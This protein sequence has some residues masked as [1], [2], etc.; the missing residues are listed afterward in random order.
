MKILFQGDS[1][2]DC[3]RRTCGGAGYEQD[4]VGPGYPGLIKS[5]LSC[6]RPGAGFEFV[7]LG[8]SGN[9]VVDLYA[10]WRA[11]CINLAPDV[12]SILI[13]VNDSW[14]EYHANG[15]EVPRYARIYGELLDWT[16][17][18]LPGVRFVLLEPFVA[19][20]SEHGGNF[21]A[22]LRERGAFVKSAAERLGPDRAVFV[23]L[24]SILDEACAAAPWTHWTA[25][26]V[27]PTPAFHQKIAD[28]WI[29]AAGRFLG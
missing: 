20:E 24:Q 25:D 9:R 10:R 8:I 16:V 12:V 7:N 29:A 2:T 23:P 27:H 3:G 19:A 14:H 22:E 21:G 11:D 6:D 17:E 4:G 13:G 18:K 5:R 1:V 15:V 26:G 28:A